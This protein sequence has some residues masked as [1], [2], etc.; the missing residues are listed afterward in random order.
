MIR[1]MPTMTMR[2]DSDDDDV[3][4][5]V[6]LFDDDDDDRAGSKGKPIGRG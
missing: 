1:V 3:D 4:D 5:D 6:L 2:L